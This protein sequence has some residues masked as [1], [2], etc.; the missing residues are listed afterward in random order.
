MMPRI[1]ITELLH[2]VAQETGFLAAFT[3]LRTGEPCPNENAM[4]AT[5]LADATNL[6]LSRMAQRCG[7][8]GSGDAAQEVER[9]GC[10]LLRV[11]EQHGPRRVQPGSSRGGFMLLAGEANS[12]S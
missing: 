2:E 12:R 3:N 6:D 10:L 4:L 8:I 11:S 9:G 1:R 7:P 5:I